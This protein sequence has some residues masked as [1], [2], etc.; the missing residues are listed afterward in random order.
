MASSK[1]VAGIKMLVLAAL[2]TAAI[3]FNAQAESLQR[4]NVGMQP[5][6]NGPLYIAIKEG[7]FKKL[8][9]DVNVVKFTSGPA[10]FAALAGGQVDLAWGGLGTFLIAKA[11]GQDL[12]FISVFMDYNSLEALVVPA[13]SAVSSIKGLAGKKVGLV[14]G[15]DANYGM[16][17]AMRANG[18][19]ADSV[20]LLNMSPPQQI[21]ALKSGDIAAAYLW[22]PFLTPLYEK[23]AR[24]LLK[25]SDLNPGSAYLGWAG[26]R[27]WL[28]AHSGAIVKLLK[29]WDMGLKKMHEDPEL[30]IRYSIEF[31]G[32]S[33]AQARAISKGLGYFKSTA[34]L[35]Q[36]SPAYWAKGSPLNKVMHRFFEFGKKGG[37]VN[38]QTAVD[39]DTLVSRRFMETV[40]AGK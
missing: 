33:E 27:S 22:E 34:A 10:Q 20:Q 13:G 36:G 40:Q 6:V 2:S 25:L 15:S 35:E 26:K 19:A 4:I 38:H 23:G 16:A 9:L 30:A 32:M 18:M 12:N 3:A 8:G 39:V 21:A 7:Y 17:E 31:T 11:N 24:T 5:I 29:G 1:L 37:L 28:D 14:K